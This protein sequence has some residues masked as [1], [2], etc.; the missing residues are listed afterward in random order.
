[1][2]DLLQSE[3]ILRLSPTGRIS[4][5]HNILFDYAVARLLLDEESFQPFINEDASRSIFFRPS[6]SFF[7][8]HLWLTDRNLFWTVTVWSLSPRRCLSACALQWRRPFTKRP[9]QLRIS[10][11]FSLQPRASPES[12]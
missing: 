2:L 8:H 5:S 3:E 7:F 10:T 12:A 4:F 1:M 11:R 6:L 9:V